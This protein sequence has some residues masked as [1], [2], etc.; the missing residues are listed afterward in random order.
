[1]EPPL[2]A[3]L[4]ALAPHTQGD[5]P[6]REVSG[7]SFVQRLPTPPPPPDPANG[8]ALAFPG[9]SNAA[10]KQMR[11]GKQHPQRD[12]DGGDVNGVRGPASACPRHRAMMNTSQTEG[13]GGGTFT[14]GTT[15]MITNIPC[16]FGRDG[17]VEAIHSVGF[18]P[19]TYDFVYVPKRNSMHEGN[20]GYAFV[21]FYEA[22]VADN[23]A[24]VFQD[25]QFPGSKSLKRCMVKHAHFQGF[26]AEL[27]MG[28]RRRSRHSDREVKRNAPKAE[29][30][31]HIEK[32]PIAYREGGVHIGARNGSGLSIAG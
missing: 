15:M 32:A 7:Q 28:E 16:R 8:Q 19:D 26:N 25:F 29:G 20:I 31:V 1:M 22:D 17:I 9:N 23:F 3:V 27:V 12:G 21:N 30:G 18:G 2:Q 14:A 24:F 13:D 4:S 10:R 11:R 5:H 6:L